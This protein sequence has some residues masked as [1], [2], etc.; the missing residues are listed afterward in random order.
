MWCY[1]AEEREKKHGS[2]KDLDIGKDVVGWLVGWLQG[3]FLVFYTGEGQSCCQAHISLEEFN[4][5]TILGKKYIGSCCWWSSTNYVT[6]LGGVG[7][8]VTP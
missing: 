2:R 6:H 3:G 8:S 4:L 5:H 7:G 1:A